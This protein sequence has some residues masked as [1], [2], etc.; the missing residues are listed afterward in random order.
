[1]GIVSIEGY[2]FLRA[3]RDKNGGEVYVFIKDAM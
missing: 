3:D 2:D 1:M